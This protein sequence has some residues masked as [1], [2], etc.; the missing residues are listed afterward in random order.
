MMI[1]IFRHAQKATD[2]SSDPDLTE[3]GHA[4]AEALLKKVLQKD[5]AMPTE[6]YVSPR[7]RTHS[8]FRSLSQHLNLPL[9][10][11][12]DLAEQTGEESLSAFRQRILAF[13]EN[14]SRKKDAVVYA[15]S[16]YDWVVEAMTV[17]PAD[18]DL[19][20][21]EFSHWSP[22]QWAAFDVDSDG[23]F[24]FVELKRIPL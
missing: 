10:M 13:L 19:T 12:E 18:T 20:T 24:H 5:L 8:T 17:I 3:S 14:H 21:A 7:I 22:C 1:Y 15:C 16:H 6:L 23:V 11:T 2:F 9:Q 4:Q